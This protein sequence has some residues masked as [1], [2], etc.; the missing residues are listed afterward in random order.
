MVLADITNAS[1]RHDE[2]EEPWSPL[3][4][5]IPK[6]RRWV[7]TPEEPP[8]PEPRRTEPDASDSPLVKRWRAE[9]GASTASDSPLVKR[10]RTE[11]DAS[12]TNVDVFQ[13]LLRIVA[14][15]LALLLGRK[16]GRSAAAAA[17]LPR[18]AGVVAGPP[19]VGRQEA[20]E[21]VVV[22]ARRPSLADSL[23]AAARARR[24]AGARRAAPLVAAA[25]AWTRARRRVARY[26]AAGC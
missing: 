2:Q 15:I 1:A 9:S 18:P 12:T 25:R 24:G 4:K 13:G 11:S 8:T 6:A 7:P 22:A 21:G 19:A 3:V 26:V 5:R 23:V 14:A 10:W 20:G 17:R 16:P